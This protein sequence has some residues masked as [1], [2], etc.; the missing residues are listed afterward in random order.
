MNRGIKLVLL[1]ASVTLMQA[2]C[3]KF[4]QIMK[5]NDYA[6]KADAAMKYYAEK[7]WLK[8]VT[9]LEDI[10]P[11]YKMTAD[12]ERY[13]FTYCMANYEM[14]DYL[15]SGY[16]FK[17]FVRQY[18]TSKNVE[19]A[20]FLSAMC[21]VKSSPMYSLDQTETINALD[22]I[23]I[24]IDLYPNSSRVDTCNRIMDDL[25]AKM[26]LK[27]YEYAMLYYRTENYKAAAVALDATLE[28]Y[29]ETI[30][31]EDILY[32]HVKSSFALAENSV[33]DKKKERYD[34]TLKSYRR[35]VA[36]FPESK[37]ISELDGLKKRAEKALELLT[38]S[39][40]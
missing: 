5:S 24:F 8:T 15:L 34:N 38:S 28:K 14:G 23:Q 40:S 21:S 6:L 26:E 11:Y 35:F 9:I 22:E 33:P 30:H 39:N 13:Y 20:L 1:L 37:R 32:Y 7:D 27:Q 29:P 18:P 19:E 4:S 36:E 2:S 17:K 16:Y 25:R 3:T 31:R 10:I 12:G